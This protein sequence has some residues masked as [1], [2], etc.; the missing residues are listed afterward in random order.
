MGYSVPALKILTAY[1]LNSAEAMDL[2]DNIADFQWWGQVDLMA[3]EDSVIRE[4]HRDLVI[5]GQ[6]RSWVSGQ[7][8]PDASTIHIH[9]AM[10]GYF[11]RLLGRYWAEIGS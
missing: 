11:E 4:Q 1:G 2:F 7:A 8:V 3:C 10:P 6:E 5:Q 9:T